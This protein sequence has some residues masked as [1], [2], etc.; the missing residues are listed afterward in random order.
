MIFGC[1]N[2][3][4]RAQFVNKPSLESEWTDVT[5]LEMYTFFGMLLYMSIARS[6]NVELYWSTETLFHGNWKRVFMSKR[7]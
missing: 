7:R 6:P 5:V 3:Y 1:S 2:N 4:G